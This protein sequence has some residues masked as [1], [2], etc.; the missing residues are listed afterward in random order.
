MTPSREG[1]ISS[2]AADNLHD[3]VV[4]P[5]GATLR[6]DGMDETFVCHVSSRGSPR[7]ELAV[8]PEA[9]TLEPDGMAEAPVCHIVRYICC[10][11]NMQMYT[12]VFRWRV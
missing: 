12:V 9:I 1:S 6:P 11:S 5:E 3:L 2:R 8:S 10:H 4:S 7:W